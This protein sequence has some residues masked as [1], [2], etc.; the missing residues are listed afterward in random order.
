MDI[1]ATLCLLVIAISAVFTFFLMKAMI[2]EM[3]K[4]EKT[5]ERL[6]AEMGHSP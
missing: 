5:V 4:L 3:K 6:L 1:L 2:R